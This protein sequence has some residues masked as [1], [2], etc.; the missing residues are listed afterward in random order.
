MKRVKDY[1]DLDRKA[2]PDFYFKPG[3]RYYPHFTEAIAEGG[4]TPF[5]SCGEIMCA[6]T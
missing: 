5:T 6:G 1:L 2:A 3:D 4:V